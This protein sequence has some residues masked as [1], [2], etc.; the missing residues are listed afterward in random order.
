MVEGA[1]NE[2]PTN[3]TKPRCYN[4]FT[5]QHGKTGIMALAL[6]HLPTSRRP[7]LR[8]VEPL[9][10]TPAGTA[11]PSRGIYVRRRL[12][13]VA[14]LMLVL[15]GAVFA[16]RAQAGE[17]VVRTAPQYVIAQEGDTI[18]R[19]AERIAPDAP[20]TDVVDELVRL[21]GTSIRVGQVILIP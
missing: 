12:T 2:A 18:W 17:A 11:R 14:V 7:H 4:G 13:V 10:P 20:V 5:P 21:N 19:I 6:D 8:L 15:A 3:P 16:S 1:P 9:D